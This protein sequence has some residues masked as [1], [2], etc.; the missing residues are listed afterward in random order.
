MLGADAAGAEQVPPGR[1]R[2]PSPVGTGRATGTGTATGTATATAT[3]TSTARVAGRTSRTGRPSRTGGFGD[4]HQVRPGEVDAEP[5]PAGGEPGRVAFG[6][7]QQV[8]DQLAADPVL[9]F[10]HRAAQQQEQRGHHAGPFEQP[11]VGV[12]EVGP[13]A[14]HHGAERVVPGEDRAH[15][16]LAVPYGPALDAGGGDRAGQFGGGCGP[17]G[18][19]LALG[20]QDRYLPAQQRRDGGG[21]VRHLGAAQHQVGEPVV[22]LLGALDGGGVGPDQFVGGVQLGERGPGV[23]QR[24]GGVQGDRGVRGQGAEQRD[25]VGREG[26]G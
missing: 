18:E 7:G 2:Q 23:G 9:G 5:A 19:R 16:L 26:A 25:L 15:P 22:R 12:V 14:Q 20:V 11:P 4:Q 8:G 10:G 13:S 3:G 21:D 6:R 1:A 24:L 17:S